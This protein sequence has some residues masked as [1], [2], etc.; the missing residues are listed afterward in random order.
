L[1]REVIRIL[2]LASLAQTLQRVE[3]TGDQRF[4]LRVAPAFQLTLAFD[5][6]CVRIVRF[7]TYESYRSSLRRVLGGE[8]RVVMRFARLQIVGVTNVE[9]V[10]NAAKDVGLPSSSENSTS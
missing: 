8:V 7:G 1:S 6:G 9:R 3:I 4:F 5:C 10:V 2:L